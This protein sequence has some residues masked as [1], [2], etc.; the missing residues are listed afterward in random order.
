MGDVLESPEWTERL[1]DEAL[2]VEPREHF[3]KAVVGTT[4]TPADHWDRVGGVAVAVYESGLWVA[5]IMEWLGCG[6]EDAQD[7][8]YFNISGSWLGEGTPVFVESDEL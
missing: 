6:A 3:D 4:R 8:F 5:A 7:W 2:L 1:S